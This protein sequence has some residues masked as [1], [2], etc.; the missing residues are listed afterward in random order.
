MT[1]KLA[2]IFRHPIKSIGYEEVRNASLT[3]GRVLPFDRVWAI[4]TEDAR[5]ESPLAEWSPKRAFLRGAAAP[6]LM[7]VQAKTHD[8]GTIEFTHPDL[9]HL[10]IDPDLPADQAK[11]IEWLRP[12]WPKNRPL[13]RAV[14]KPGVALTDSQDPFVSVLSLDSL[15]AFAQSTGQEMSPH[16]FR[17]NL[18]VRGWQ[19][20]AERAMVGQTLH[21]GAAEIE[22]IEPIVRCRATCANPVTGTEDFDTL[23]ALKQINGDTTFGLFG[24]VRRGADIARNDEI[25]VSP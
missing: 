1:G 2:H 25:K 22:I 14:E 8:D 10:R 11:L 13:P 21:I 20:W 5:F 12:L 3:E 17:G 23:G 19:P 9:W 18:W 6:A 4:S 7:A 24:I 16:R 15:D